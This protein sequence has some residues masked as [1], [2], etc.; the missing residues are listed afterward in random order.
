MSQSI[1]TQAGPT[2]SPRLDGRVVDG[3]PGDMQPETF[4]P[5]ITREMVCDYLP[6]LYQKGLLDRNPPTHEEWALAEWYLAQDRE[7]SPFRRVI[8]AAEL[9]Q[10]HSA[11]RGK[12]LQ[13]LGTHGS[14][15]TGG[16]KEPALRS[17]RS[18]Q[19]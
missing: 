12:I 2:S 8:Y 11:L 19:K 9:G 4:L 14:A 16:S 15:A 18:I 6:L 1:L 3:F 10:Q 5:G 17:I 7:S 13:Q